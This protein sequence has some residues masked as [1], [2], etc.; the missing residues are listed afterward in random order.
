LYANISYVDF[1]GFVLSMS[2]VAGDGSVQLVK[3]LQPGAVVA[4][5]ADLTAQAAIDGAPWDSLCMKDT[6]GKV[7]R[8]LAPIHLLDLKPGSFDTYFTQYINDVWSAYSSKD[9]T[10]NTQGTPGNVACRV[11]GDTLNCAGDNRGYAKP[12]ARDIFGCDSGTMYIQRD[13]DNAVHYAVAPRLCAAFTRSTLLL[14]SGDVQPS[15]DATQ[16]YTTSP[17]NR[18]SQFVHRYELDNKGYSFAYDDV[19]PNGENAAGV[20]ADANP[21]LLTIY[22][23]GYPN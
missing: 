19:N 12:V 3:G 1:I 20:V 18:Y 2:M 14:P 11:S 13:T 16:Y 22:V 21:Q 6:S 5:C 9:L 4:I 15:L 17:T 7:M 8:V 23:G 10:I